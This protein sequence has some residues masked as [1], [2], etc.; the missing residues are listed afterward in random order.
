MIGTLALA[1]VFVEVDPAASGLDFVHFNG[2]SG[3]FYFQEMMGSGAALIDYDR[4]GDL[5]V[6]L[7]Q[8]HWLGDHDISEAIFAPA[9]PLPMSDRLYRN[10]GL[11]DGIPRF[12]DVTEQL[13]LTIARGYG[14]GV[15]VGDY[16]GD[17]YDDLYLSNYGSNQLLRNVAGQRFEDVTASA[18]VDDVRWSV[19]AAFLDY[20]G[21]GDQDL[22]VGNYVRHDMAEQRT[23]RFQA[24]E[25][26]YCGPLR[27][28][29]DSDSLFRNDGDGTFTDVSTSSGLGALRGGA[30]GVSVADFDGDGRIDIY[31]A[32]DGV[33]NRLWINQGPGEDGLWRFHDDALLAGVS[34]NRD[35]RAEASMGVDAA[36]LD[37][38]GDVDL[39]MTHLSTETNT[40]YLNDG[41]GWFEDRTVGRGMGAVS[42]E[43]TGFGTAFLD[44]DNDGH[45][46][47]FAANGE[48]RKVAAQ[49]EAELPYPLAQR[50]QLFRNDG[51]AR[52]VE[53]TAEAGAAMRRE[54]VGRGAAFGDVDGD[55][56]TDVLVAN[57]AGPA[58]L[59][60]N[61]VGSANGWVGLE[62][63]DRHGSAVGA[64]VSLMLPDGSPAVRRARREGSY[65]SSND[66][67]VLIGLGAAPPAAVTVR[68][69]WPS[70]LEQTITGLAT[71]RYHQL[72]EPG[73]AQEPR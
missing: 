65:A 16:D 53:V 54:E 15:A 28:D 68:V 50:N 55:G 64:T 17:G 27:G 70:G 19:S 5:D 21:D 48:I 30:L 40:L 49:V 39:F 25:L 7:V 3:R 2:M 23:C 18:G 34:V 29:G 10:D 9:H 37:G 66:P 8:G 61:Q 11:R 24:R 26:D 67:R 57:N 69:R 32:N 56:D 45:L 47:V 33:E 36:D 1:A 13:G 44:Y 14:M 46:D 62:L 38:D 4:D 72:S 63:R 22:F 6:Y 52:F 60:L 58:R 71:G 42:F 59:L 43:Y 35:G 31:V 12:T 20:D 73:E 41:G 51:E